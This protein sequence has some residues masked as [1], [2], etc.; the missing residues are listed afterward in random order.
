M[1][2]HSSFSMLFVLYKYVV[3]QGTCFFVFIFVH[4]VIV[5]RYVKQFAIWLLGLLR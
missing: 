2:Y 5:A 3:L 4:M 1:L